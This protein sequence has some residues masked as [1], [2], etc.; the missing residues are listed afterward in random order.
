[1]QYLG[2]GSL[3]SALTNMTFLPLIRNNLLMTMSY[4]YLVPRCTTYLINVISACLGPIPNVDIVKKQ[5]NNVD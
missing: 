3:V 4:Y 5:E 1:M 2:L